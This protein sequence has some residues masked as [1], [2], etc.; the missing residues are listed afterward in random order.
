MYKI[1]HYIYG[2]IIILISS[3]FSVVLF[4]LS[5]RFFISK[6]SLSNTEVANIL[7]DFNYE[8]KLNNL[9]ESEREEVYYQ[10]DKYGLRSNC[11]NTKDIKILTVG[12]STTDQ[13]YVNLES[14]FQSILESKINKYI[15]KNICIA[16]AGV[17]G[18]TTFGHI[19]SFENW[20]PLIPDLR[21]NYII[22][23]IGINDADFIR[24]GAN[25]GYDINDTSTIVGFLKNFY[26]FQKILPLVRYI[27]YNFQKDN[28]KYASHSKNNFES[29]DYTITEINPNTKELS[30]VN[31]KSFKK[32][33]TIILN[34]IEQLGSQHICISQPHKFVNNIS[35][36]KKGIPA[37]FGK[38]YSGLDFDYSLSAL[39]KIMK[40]LCGKY[41]IDIKNEEFK[42]IHFYDG[43]H[44][45]KK[46]SEFLGNLIYEKMKM[47]GFLEKL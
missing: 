12:G 1:K 15:N 43:V 23:Y 9:Y 8:Y 26:V 18:H 46:G 22:L 32:R 28:L 3:F 10:R 17:D 2:I 30:E 37:T 31:A 47:K 24:K 33:L 42:E 21:P 27:N 44:T 36:I 16:N 41:F 19:Y 5:L 38:D 7:R 4:E 25:K 39:N 40:N 6:D 20:F 13:R 14:T 11:K 35:D 34:Q 29:K 45:T